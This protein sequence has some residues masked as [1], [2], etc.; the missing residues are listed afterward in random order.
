MKPIAAVTLLALAPGF[1]LCQFAP[2]FEVA[3]IRLNKDPRSGTSLEFPPGRERFA[4]ANAS[5][6]LLIVTA[7]DVTIPQFAWAKSSL[8][9]LFERYDI[10]A[11]AGHP[12]RRDEML[13]MLQNLLEER[14]KLLVHRE[15]KDLEA[16]VLVVDHGGEK[17]SPVLHLSDLPHI[18]DATPLN[19][20]H[21]RGT[22]PSSGYLA[23]KD[24]TMADFAWRLSS[25]VALGGRVVVDKTGLNDHYDF[26]LKFRPDL[27]VAPPDAAN[28]RE[29]PPDAAPS[30]FTAIREQ[31]GLRLLP[32][33]LPIEILNV[34][35]AEK[36]TENQ[37]EPAG[38][39]IA[40]AWIITDRTITETITET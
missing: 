29:S 15:T 31:L 1:A 24:E 32:Q 19:P 26:E 38:D 28:G 5:L 9:V 23:F 22:E 21:A 8:P 17:R 12:V 39:A 14:F 16:Y 30:I 25:L 18:N 35:R 20:Y 7:Y 4:A 36:P 13:H 40:S 3:S 11:R 37:E 27:S 6:N 10:Q 2:S 34:E 33:K